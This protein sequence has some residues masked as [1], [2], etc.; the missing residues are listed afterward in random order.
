MK[1]TPCTMPKMLT[2]SSVVSVTYFRNIPVNSS[3]QVMASA[4]A[5]TR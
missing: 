5:A 3:A 2:P 4:V 1:T